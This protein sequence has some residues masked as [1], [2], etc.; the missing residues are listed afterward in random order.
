MRVIEKYIIA[1][2]LLLVMAA[3]TVWAQGTGVLIGVPEQNVIYSGVD[4]PLLVGAIGTVG[5]EWVVTC[6]EADV[7]E[8]QGVW[9]IHPTENDS[10]EWVTV[11]IYRKGAKGKNVFMGDKPF[12]VMSHPEQLACIVTPSHVYRTGDSVPV[13]V[14]Q[15]S[16]TRV[17]PR[18]HEYMDYSESD[19]LMEQFT[20]VCRQKYLRCANDTLS[21]VAKAAIAETLTESDAVE[22]VIQAPRI[23]KRGDKSTTLRTLQSSNFTIVRSREQQ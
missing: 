14:I 8:R 21:T 17:A 3:E 2:I 18:Y 6:R 13:A 11:T 23:G 9:Y 20:V 19:L 16:T 5:N 15:D 12:R 7:F 4:N 22:I 1:T 10:I